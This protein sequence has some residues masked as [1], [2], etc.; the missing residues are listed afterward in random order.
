MCPSTGGHSV[1]SVP[2]RGLLMVSAKCA[3][4]S[5]LWQA[6]ICSREFRALHVPLGAR[7]PSRSLQAS[8]PA[9]QPI[10]TR[11]R[12]VETLPCHAV[13]WEPAA[14]A[15][16]ALASLHGQP[17]WACNRCA[18]QA[19]GIHEAARFLAAG[20]QWSS[21]LCLARAWR[22]APSFATNAAPGDHSARARQQ[23]QHCCTR[24]RGFTGGQHTLRAGWMRHAAP[25]QGLAAVGGRPARRARY[26]GQR[27][28]QPVN[29]HA[30]YCS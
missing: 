26:A 10:I 16:A 13:T 23:Q 30:L 24:A 22:R 15:A 5:G 11:E 27:L 3:N 2:F 9:S 18:K 14:A 20:I 8:Q 29:R 21:L 12:R 17:R 1:D 25:M 7:G 19:A 4:M 28:T 6:G